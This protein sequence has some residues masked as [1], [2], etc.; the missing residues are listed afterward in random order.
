MTA[1]GQPLTLGT[2]YIKI[3][4]N[5]TDKYHCPQGI[6]VLWLENRSRQ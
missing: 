3:V 5:N 2:Q 1:M 6:P 4:N